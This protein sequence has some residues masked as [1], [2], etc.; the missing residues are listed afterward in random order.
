MRPLVV[1][2]KAFLFIHGT[3][4]QIRLLV[5]QPRS[6]LTLTKAG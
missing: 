1:N 4:E 5:E 6:R 3:S 2:L